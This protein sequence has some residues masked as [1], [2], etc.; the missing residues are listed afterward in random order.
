MKLWDHDRKVVER[1]QHNARHPDNPKNLRLFVPQAREP[2]DS[3][4][5]STDDE[6]RSL[7]GFFDRCGCIIPHFIVWNFKEQ[8]M[9][10]ACNMSIIL[11]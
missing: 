6:W 7:A 10:V 8:V 1:R 11:E 5:N 2:L 4:D 9:Y 3:L